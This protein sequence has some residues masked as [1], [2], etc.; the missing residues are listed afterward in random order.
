M[1]P[2]ESESSHISQHRKDEFQA[3]QNSKPSWELVLGQLITTWNFLE[4]NPG[5][6]L[7]LWMEFAI[8][9][10]FSGFSKTLMAKKLSYCSKRC[11]INP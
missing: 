6:E 10:H 5:F 4:V 7:L 1:C 8:S 9:I 11:R 3:L 2:W